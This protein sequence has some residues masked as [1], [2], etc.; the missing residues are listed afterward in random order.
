[1]IDSIDSLKDKLKNPPKDGNVEGYF[2]NLAD[3]LFQNTQ[4]RKGGKYYRF[5]NIEFY[6]YND[7]HRDIIT[8]P[9]I[10]DGGEWFFHASGVDITFKSSVEMGG[11]KPILTEDAYFGGILIRGIAP[12]DKVD[13]KHEIA[14][15]IKVC[16]ELF[17]K[18][19]AFDVPT[20]FPVLV[21]VPGG[22]IYNDKAGRK[23]LKENAQEKVSSILKYNYSYNDEE[24]KISRS[25]LEQQYSKYRVQPYA[26]KI[27]WE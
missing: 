6:L 11:K 25:G 16:D 5:T 7:R 4:I 8:Y 12:A 1:M 27:V 13:K 17:D 21:W 15:P 26:Y 23:G 14:G 24:A 20:D 3:T 19:N 9:R 18:F 10:S 2:K 22:R